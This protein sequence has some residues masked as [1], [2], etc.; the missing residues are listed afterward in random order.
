MQH[1]HQIALSQIVSAENI[2]KKHSV[3]L[4]GHATSVTLEDVYWQLLDDIA[5][6][7]QKSRNGLITEIDHKR[8]IPLS[9]ALRL[10]C[11]HHILETSKK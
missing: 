11:L 5:K 8:A 2:V 1:A 6:S 7:Q 10:Y 4:M 3:M 9:S